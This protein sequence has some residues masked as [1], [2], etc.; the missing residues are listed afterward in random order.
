MSGEKNGRITV[1]GGPQITA[2]NNL[3]ELQ[4]KKISNPTEAI[5]TLIALGKDVPLPSR[6]YVS[7]HSTQPQ[8]S[9]QAQ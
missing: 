6:N 1:I 4:T 5:A 9:T 7:Q 8:Q 3:Q 2:Q